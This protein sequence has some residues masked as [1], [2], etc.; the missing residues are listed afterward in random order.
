MQNQENTDPVTIGSYTLNYLF[1]ADDVVL[2]STSS[3]G[4]QNCINALREFSE[5][6]K[7]E[8]NLDKTKVLT[9]NNKGKETQNKYKYG[10]EL[11]QPTDKYTYLG[12]DLDQT[13][14]FKQAINTLHNKGLKALYKMQ[15][16]QS[17]VQN[18]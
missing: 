7:L 3:E 1:Y 12:I 2:I 6:W 14:T 15:Q 13:G 10:S 17:C 9:F 18:P 5:K 16:L 11:I 8:I 4:L